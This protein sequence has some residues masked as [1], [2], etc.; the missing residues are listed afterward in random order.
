MVESG[1]S[2][3]ARPWSRNRGAAQALPLAGERGEAV[4]YLRR[5]WRHYAGTSIRTRIQ[6][7]INLQPRREAGPGLQVTDCA[8][9]EASGLTALRGKPGT[10]VLLGPLVRRLQGSVARARAVEVGIWAAA[11]DGS[12]DSAVW[13]CSAGEEAPPPAERKYIGEVWGKYYASLA[14]VPVPIGSDNFRNYGASTT[15]TLVL[16]DSNGVVRLYHPGNLSYEELRQA[17][18][19]VIAR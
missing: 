13:I 15:P 7:N 10:A 6:K 19:Q 5:S 16:I 11:S 4:A 12:A 14:D 18:V 2:T 8:G 9:P 1:R 17:V 3:G